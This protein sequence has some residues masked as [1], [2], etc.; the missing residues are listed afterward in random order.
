MKRVVTQ[1]MKLLD[2]YIP[3]PKPSLHFFDPF[4]TLIA[5]L[6]SAVCTDVRVNAVTKILFSVAS[7]PEAMVRLSEEEIQAII[8]P[9]G[10]SEKKAKAI[11]TL[12]QMLIDRFGGKVPCS[13]DELQ[14]L[15]GVGLKTASVVLSQAFGIPTFPV[16]T[17]IFRL[18]H[19]WG[20][21]EGRT[22]AAVARDLEKLFPKAAWGRVHLQM[23]LYGRRFCSARRHNVSA[24]PI[25]SWKIKQ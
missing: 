3:D 15:P 11:K 19:R 24:C 12:S 21:S 23:V 13:L 1:I 9:C 16:D 5:V 25:C 8:R 17:H 2:T 10:L 4:T 6:L 7:T 14:V 22:P 20:L 18:A